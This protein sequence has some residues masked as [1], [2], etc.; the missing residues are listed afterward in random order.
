[1]RDLSSQSN[2]RIEREQWTDH[3]WTVQRISAYR[4]VTDLDFKT[5]TALGT[6]G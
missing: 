1:M 5:C 4:R 6:I 3:P 2:R